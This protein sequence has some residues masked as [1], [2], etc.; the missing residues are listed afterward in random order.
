MKLMSGTLFIVLS[1][2]FATG[3]GSHQ[4]DSTLAN[5]PPPGAVLIDDSLLPLFDVIPVGFML[6]IENH[7]SPKY[8]LSW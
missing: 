4:D 3:C 2:A 7:I 1:V 5:E 8:Q 6:Y